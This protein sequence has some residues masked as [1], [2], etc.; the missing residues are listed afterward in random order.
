[1]IKKKVSI[2]SF[3]NKRKKG[4]LL[5]KRV[6]LYYVTNQVCNYKQKKIFLSQSLKIYHK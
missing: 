5:N 2:S 4:V 3:K 6:K 1:M